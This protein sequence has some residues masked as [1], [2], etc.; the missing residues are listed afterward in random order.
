M[1]WPV[2]QR[3]IPSVAEIP[4]GGV[5]TEI[6]GWSGAWWELGLTLHSLGWLWYLWPRGEVEPCNGK[7]WGLETARP[8]GSVSWSPDLTLKVGL[9]DSEVTPLGFA[10]EF[11]DNWTLLGLVVPGSLWEAVEPAPASRFTSHGPSI[12]GNPQTLEPSF[13][14]SL[15][16]T[17]RSPSVWKHHAILQRTKGSS[18][19]NEKAVVIAK[20][21]SSFCWEWGSTCILG[22]NSL[23]MWL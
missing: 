3:Q 9:E 8:W 5:L 13:N 12:P 6:C 2:Y 7:R 15:E 19:I 11:T 10:F 23:L 1:C 20:S 16:P 14:P 21:R 17:G 18:I 22:L 4:W